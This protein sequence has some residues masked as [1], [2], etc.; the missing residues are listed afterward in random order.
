MSPFGKICEVFFALELGYLLDCAEAIVLSAIDRTESRG[1][2][3]RTDYPERND[4]EWLKHILVSYSPEGI[5]TDY[6]P[7]TITQ[8]APKARTY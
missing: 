2:Q 3:F 5:R 4:E 8:W 7:V 6:T 1:A